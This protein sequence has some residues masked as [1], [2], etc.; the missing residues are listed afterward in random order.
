MLFDYFWKKLKHISNL[1]I[2]DD[3]LYLHK[4]RTQIGNQCA[5]LI[6]LFLITS[7][8]SSILSSSNRKEL[9]N[10]LT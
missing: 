10:E 5:V 4:T 2:V 7:S 9:P 8:M 6:F 3:Q 1:G